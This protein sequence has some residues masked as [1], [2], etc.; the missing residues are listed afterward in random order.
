MFGEEILIPFKEAQ[1]DA[2]IEYHSTD[3]SR[4][5]KARVR[6]FDIFLTIS[7]AAGMSWEE[8]YMAWTSFILLISGMYIGSE[9]VNVRVQ[10][11]LT[12]VGAER[13]ARRGG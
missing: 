7:L 6:Y 13:G 1:L 9:S 5:V 8:S 12:R 10:W 2:R 11:T 3:C 4:L